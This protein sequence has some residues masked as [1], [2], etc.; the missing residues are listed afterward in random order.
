MP[1]VLWFQVKTLH[2]LRLVSASTPGTAG[3]SVGSGAAER[4]AIV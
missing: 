3:A 1:E 2:F 4:F